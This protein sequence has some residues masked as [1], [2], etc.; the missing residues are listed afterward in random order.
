MKIYELDAGH[1]TKMVA[2]FIYG[3]TLYKAS[4]PEPLD[5]FQGNL[6]VVSG[7][8]AHQTLFKL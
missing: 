8:P 4:S 2:K 7:A 5:Q 3:K 6:Y 1:M